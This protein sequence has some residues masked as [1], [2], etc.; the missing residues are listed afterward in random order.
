MIMRQQLATLNK[1]ISHA[2][3]NL[4]DSAIS[5]IHAW[6]GIWGTL[7]SLFFKTNWFQV[8]VLWVGWQFHKALKLWIF[9]LF[10]SFMGST[11]W[12]L[13]QYKG[14]GLLEPLFKRFFYWTYWWDHFSALLKQCACFFPD[15]D[16]TMSHIGCY[17]V[18][19]QTQ[20][21]PA[22]H[23]FVERLPE[24]CQLVCCIRMC[25]G[26]DAEKTDWLGTSHLAAL[27]C[28]WLQ[29]STALLSFLWELLCFVFSLLFVWKVYDD[30]KHLI[31]YH[32]SSANLQFIQMW[33]ILV[34]TRSMATINP[35]LSS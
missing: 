5:C 7:A 35:S 32:Y 18:V 23:S 22:A 21:F 33:W 12:P 28:S 34:C 31:Y 17:S 3:L 10:P 27:M 4:S 29:L 9:K 11:C 26:I 15:S 1:H 8:M 20:C 16:N 13:T 19:M 24:I 30:I 14:R 25:A 6:I 2:N